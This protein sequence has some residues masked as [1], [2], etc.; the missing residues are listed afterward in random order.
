MSLHVART[1]LPDL[2]GAVTNIDVDTHGAWVAACELPLGPIVVTSQAR[3]DSPV[4]G[5]EPLVRLLENGDVLVIAPRTL[6]GVENACICSPTGRLKTR[7][8]V[9]DGVEDAIVVGGR[10]VCSY[11]DE[12]VL[13]GGE[14]SGDGVS[15]FDVTGRQV[16]GYHADVSGA[17]QIVDCY[18]VAQSA[19]DEICFSAYMDFEIVMLNVHTGRQRVHALPEELHGCTAISAK[20]AEFVLHSPYDAKGD[21]F[22][23]SPGAAPVWVGTHNGRLRGCASGEFLGPEP[24]GYTTIRVGSA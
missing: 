1:T 5:A 7:F 15:V 12:G 24:E 8:S 17:I 13:H 18:C 2:P 4:Q 9:G 23:W 6:R 19:P 20:G 11:F 10:I 22:C 3:F 16:L 14:Y 21:L